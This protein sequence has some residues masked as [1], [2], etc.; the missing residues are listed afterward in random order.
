MEQ[1]LR[2]VLDNVLALVNVK[3]IEL[4]E[5]IDEMSESDVDY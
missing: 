1:Q 2:Y 5:E 4:E 3:R